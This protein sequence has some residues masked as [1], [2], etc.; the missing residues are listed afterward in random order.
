MRAILEFNLPEDREEYELAVKAGSA[1][2][3]LDDWE[4]QLRGWCKY[5]LPEEAAKMG[6]E[7]L[8]HWVREQYYLTMRED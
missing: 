4:R 1:A 6:P 2:A 8:I 5:A 3:R 7:D